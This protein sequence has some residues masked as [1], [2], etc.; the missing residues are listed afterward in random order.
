VS[1]SVSRVSRERQD[2]SRERQLK[3]VALGPTT[4]PFPEL[5]IPLT[6]TGVRESLARPLEPVPT[7]PPHLGVGGQLLLAVLFKAPLKMASATS[8]PMG[9]TIFSVAQI[10]VVVLLVGTLWSYTPTC[11]QGEKAAAATAAATAAPI[12]LAPSLATIEAV[13]SGE[14]RRRKDIP[15]PAGAPDLVR[16]LFS[17]RAGPGGFVASPFSGL[18][19]D[20]WPLDLQGWNGNDPELSILISTAQP[21]VRVAVEVGSWKGQSTNT[22]SNALKLLPPVVGA[23]PPVLLAI[24]TWLGA[25]EFMTLKA[26]KGHVESHALALV[27]GQPHIYLQFLANMLHMGHEDTVVPIVQSS[28][29]AGRFLQWARVRAQFIYV[30]ASH[31]TEDLFQDMIAYFPLLDASGSVLVGDDWNWPSVKEGVARFVGKFCQSQPT[32]SGVKWSLFKHQCVPGPAIFG[33]DG[34]CEGC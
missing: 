23:P 29:L 2:K 32:V 27:H 12:C 28:V 34:A 14:L 3:A 7:T 15:F 6:F 33:K 20:D 13:L 25:L 10:V 24:D 31:D 19:K 1:L 22:I 4:F 21:S 17:G 26:S 8:P 16:A 18:A 11:T 9:S 5:K 30:D